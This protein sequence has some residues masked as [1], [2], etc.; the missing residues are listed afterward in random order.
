MGWNPKPVIAVS[1]YPV[2]EPVTTPAG[3][4]IFDGYKRTL[5]G[6]AVIN[7]G[8]DD[9]WT[10]P[11]PAT[12]RF[13][14][15]DPNRWWVERVRARSAVGTGC[16]MMVRLPDGENRADMPNGEF[17]LFQGF[18]SNVKVTEHRARTTRG[19]VSG[20]L[21]EITAGD[22]TSMLGNVLFTWEDWPAERMIDR[23][24]RLRDRAA[25]IGIRQF[26]YEAAYKESAVRPIELRDETALT[27]TRDLY[28]SFAHQWTYSQNRNVVIRIPEHR[29]NVLPQFAVVRGEADVILSM[30]NLVDTTGAESPIDTAPH[31]GTGVDGATTA[32]GLELDSDQI[33]AISRVEMTWK[34]V[35]D[36]Y[37]TI[38][39]STVVA[40]SE[41]PY[42]TLAF[43]SWYSDGVQA[44][45]I[46]AQAA[47]KAFGS[48][49]G[50]HHPAITVDTRLTDGFASVG[51]G[52]ALLSAVE[53]HGYVYVNGSPWYE[54]T[55]QLPVGAPAG[56]SIT[57]E[58]GY[59]RTETRLLATDGIAAGGQLTYDQ[60]PKG[61]A[62]GHPRPAGLYQFGGVNWWDLYHPASSS[63]YYLN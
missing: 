17:T 52:I 32:G 14:V 49:A 23:A 53:A 61:I 43:E 22:R 58:R 30:P 3:E 7:W 11:E 50:P 54:A 10:Q 2:C 48:Q 39:S 24:V 8:R 16:S 20:H 47:N 62:W 28:Q 26:Y 1:E 38:I 12:L 18:V 6:K 31:V 35:H 55:S 36:N 63:I 45:P 56:G 60:F 34:N 4:T 25:G 21:V 27:I 37:R 15:F 29:F 44:D 41:P 51:Q 59:W 42:R 19:E 46:R 5:V 33:A 40:G 9:P 57:Y 13:T